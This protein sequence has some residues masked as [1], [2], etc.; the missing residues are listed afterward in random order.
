VE[1]EKSQSKQSM[2]S[3]ALSVGS[4][5]LGA[6]MG[7]KKITATNIGRA[8][9][10]AR[11]AGRSMKESQDVQRAEE[12]VDALATQKVN[13]EEQLQQEID[14]LA[15]TIDPLTEKLIEVVLKPKKTN[16]T[17]RL[18]ALAWTPLWQT[19]GGATPAWE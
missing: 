6:L 9:T 5:I 7:R 14:K 10:A 1:R 18:V 12:N 3:T 19:P 13:L 15:V 16:I 17:V 4:S 2:F 8:T 11:S